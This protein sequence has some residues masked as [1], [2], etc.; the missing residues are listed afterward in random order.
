[1]NYEMFDKRLIKYKRINSIKQLLVQTVPDQCKKSMCWI[2]KRITFL[3][4]RNWDEKFAVI[5]GEFA[6]KFSG[7]IHVIIFSGGPRSTIWGKVRNL[8][9]KMG[10]RDYYNDIWFPSPRCEVVL[11]D[12]T[13]TVVTFEQF[14]AGYCYTCN[15]NYYVETF[16]HENTWLIV[17][18][19]DREDRLIQ[20]CKKPKTLYDLCLRKIYCI[21]GGQ[22]MSVLKKLTCCSLRTCT[23]DWR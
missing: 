21:E 14:F 8:C 10:Q 7:K 13:V 15:V 3:K 2:V 23:H 12:V 18:N 19:I 4:R 16:F 20:V 17:K 6:E 5:S 11:G 1:M 22:S 9:L